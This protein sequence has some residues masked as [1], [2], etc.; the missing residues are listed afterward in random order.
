MK[1]SEIRIVEYDPV[2]PI[3]FTEE[4]ERLKAVMV[5]GYETINHIGSTAVIG[6]AA[7]PCI[8]ISM[9]VNV[10]EEME[11]YKNKLDCLG[12]KHANGYHFEKWYLF[13]KKN[14]QTWYHLHIM[15]IESLRWREQIVFRIMMQNNVELAKKYE[16]LKKYYLKNDIQ[17]F[18]SMNKKPF[19]DN[20][21][22]ASCVDLNDLSWFKNR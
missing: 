12:Y 4:R 2:W 9:I 17:E 15:P 11:D 10:F 22:K 18:Y 16:W 8:D 6:M 21:V 14:E 19:V 5:E 20:I 7:K 13:D 1:N 3:L